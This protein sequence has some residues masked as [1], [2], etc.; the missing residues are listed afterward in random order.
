MVDLYLSRKIIHL[1]KQHCM[2][3]FLTLLVLVFSISALSAQ[4]PNGATVPNFTAKDINGRT[5]DLYEILESGR[6]VVIDVSATWCGPCWNYH[7]AKHLENYFAAHGPEGDGKS[8][9][10]F[11]E[12]DGSTNLACLYGGATC[13]GGTQ[14][15]WVEGTSY[16]IIDNAAIS[17][18]F[19]TTY[20]PTGMLVCP[21]KTNTQVDQQ[22]AS[23]LWTKASACV[24]NIPANFAKLNTLVPGTRAPEIC[25][26]QT[27]SPTVNL[28]NLGS[29][30]VSKVVV[31]LRWNDQLLQTKT[32]Q[33]AT[34]VLD[35]SE[36]TFDPIQI[37]SV[38]TL[39][40]E[41]ISVNDVAN[42]VV[43][44]VT[45][46][47]LPAQEKLTQQQIVLNIRTDVNSADTYW[48]AYDDAGNELAHGGN[49]AVGINGGGQFPNGSPADPTAY[50]K[51]TQIRDTFAI[52]ANSCFTLVM[53]DG[54]GDGIT[55]PG[56]VRLF[57]LGN[58]TAFYTK[59]GDFG[60]FD[61]H[62]FASKTSGT[63]EPTEISSFE[64]FPNPAVNHLMVAY[65]LDSASDCQ[66]SVSNATGQLVRTQTA[67]PQALGQNQYDLNLDGLSNGMYFV[68][69]Q[70]NTGMKT[71]RFV[72]A[73]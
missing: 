37:A 33:T 8:F 5:W 9:V 21:D 72:V 7:N 31:E 4:L 73:K 24:G 39:S 44:K 38:G 25:G 3:R 45:A 29:V 22:S 62:A 35:V 32:F 12:G 14:G 57:E 47:I 28:T 68:H 56:L 53:V 15:N 60:A 65:T 26:N 10:F 71:L 40:A 2:K 69:L 70:T 20:F 61:R 30:Q 19:E 34:G 43:S 51:N 49:A 1:V 54:K 36:L 63:I 52:P 16:P 64:V 23:A 55:P 58:N 42:A 41:V 18:S 6:P 66:L 27:V 46:D 17:N 11:I 48:A 13:N 50:P 59:I 67:I